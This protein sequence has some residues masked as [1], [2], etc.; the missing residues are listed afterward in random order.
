MVRELSRMV[1]HGHSAINRARVMFTCGS[2]EKFERI[3]HKGR[4]VSGAAPAGRRE[5]VK[6]HPLVLSGR[7]V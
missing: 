3:R 5:I 7:L 4:S 2:S 6:H 1:P